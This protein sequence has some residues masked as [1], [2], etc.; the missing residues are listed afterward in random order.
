MTSSGMQ[1]AMV[2]LSGGRPIGYQL[3]GDTPNASVLSTLVADSDAN[4]HLAWIDTAGFRAYDV[5]YA[6]TAPEAKRWLDRTTFEDVLLGA[7][8][9]VWGIA[10]GVSLI[11]IVAI[12]NMV[13]TMWVV[14]FY[15]IS[16]RE[17]LKDT[18][19]KIGLAVA[20]VI[21]TASK[22]LFLPG[23]SAGPPFSFRLPEQI[24]S[25]IATAKPVVILALG[26]LAIHLYTRRSRRAT[27]FMAYLIFAVTD[28]LLTMVVYAPQFLRPP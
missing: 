28:G 16:R 13:P 24:A 23:L 4:L 21:Y 1:L 19:A 8:S 15:A 6:T 25:L 17:Y 22:L 18:G 14:S 5:Y 11:P 27:L 2:V 3:V 20:I 7:A 10:S 12:W 26:L 9:L